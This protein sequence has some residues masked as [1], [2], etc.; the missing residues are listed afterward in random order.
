[1]KRSNATAAAKRAKSTF[2]LKLVDN[3]KQNPSVFW[4]YVRENAK[5]CSDVMSLRK[6][7][8]SRTFSD[9][10][11]AQCLNLLQCKSVVLQ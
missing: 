1:M 7:D 8:G 10:E 9:R 4:K 6:E 5:V 11:T 3:V 2:E